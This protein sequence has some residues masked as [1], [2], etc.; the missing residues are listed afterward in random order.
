MKIDIPYYLITVVLYY[1]MKTKFPSKIKD[2]NFFML[3][4][5]SFN[6][7]TLISYIYNLKFLLIL[8]NA[9]VFYDTIKTWINGV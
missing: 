5:I 9:F 2:D 1:V 6:C 4:Y 7:I 8:V 3:M